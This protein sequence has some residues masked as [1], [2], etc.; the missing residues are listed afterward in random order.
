MQKPKKIPMRMCLGCGEHKPKR[1]L[2]RIVKNKEGEI[3]ID[4]TG[5]ATGRGAYVCVS[6]DCLE[7]CKKGRKLNRAFS[8][9]IPDEIYDS[10]IGELENA[11]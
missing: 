11:E 5:Q 9:E 7:K 10:L 6:I 2:M 8:C 4:L 3:S 1:E